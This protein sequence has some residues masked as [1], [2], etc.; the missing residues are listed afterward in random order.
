[1]VV[2]F[3]SQTLY[4]H[5]LHDQVGAE[6]VVSLIRVSGRVTL[7]PGALTGGRQTHHEQ[8]FGICEGRW[9]GYTGVDVF[10]WG[11][12]YHPVAVLE[13]SPG[14]LLTKIQ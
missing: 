7:T 5:L 10:G 13:W 1:M 9:S 2:A 4:L 11:E 3:P 12:C 14:W 8:K 6:Y